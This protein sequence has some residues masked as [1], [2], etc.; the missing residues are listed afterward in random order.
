MKKEDCP[1]CF[2]SSGY[3]VFTGRCTQKCDTCNGSGNITKA[4][5]KKL[6]KIYGDL[7][8]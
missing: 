3:T 1:M 2:N 4:K 6:K 8:D 7:I 5:H